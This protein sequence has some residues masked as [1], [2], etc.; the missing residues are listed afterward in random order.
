MGSGD[1]LRSENMD[2]A[3]PVL[4]K[5]LELG[6]TTFDTA[7]HYRHSEKAL[8]KWMELRNNREE[9]TILTK[10]CHP[11]REAPNQPRVNAQ[12]I[13]EDLMESLERLKTKYVDLYALH[14]DDPHT[15]VEELMEALH[16]LVNKGI[17]RAIGVSNW[18]VNRILEANEYANQHQLVPF[19]FNSPNLSLAKC[20]RPRWEGCV[21]AD[22][23]MISWHEKT[24]LPLLSW[25]SQ[26]GGFFSGR[27][28]PEDQFNQE[29]VEVYYSDANW[30]RFSRA[31]QLAE[32][33]QVTPIQIALAYVLNQSFAT[34]ALI[35]PE[36]ITELLSSYEGAQL[37]LTENEVAWLD[38]Q[39]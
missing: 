30:E 21:S 26:A 38:L 18:E 16:K 8:G 28:T 5:F 6:G 19:T 39:G 12:A 13:H 20:N 27:F 37:Q 15:P 3:A 2:F 1:F 10:G 24:K 34:A 33:K 11:T 7:F 17:I 36:N 23:S 22:Q 35:G 4:D 9:L 25:S 32:K 14:R 29:M 31:Q